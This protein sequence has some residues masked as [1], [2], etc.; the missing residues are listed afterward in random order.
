MR[1]LCTLELLLGVHSL[2]HI[3]R[4]LLVLLVPW[5]AWLHLHVLLH[6]H[7]LLGRYHHGLALCVELL[8]H[9]WLVVVSYHGVVLLIALHEELALRVVTWRV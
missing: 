2:H 5:L 1:E 8:L 9:E 4:H 7:L 6:D 3:R